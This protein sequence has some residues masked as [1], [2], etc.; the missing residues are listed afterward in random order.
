M[1]RKPF[2]YG[3]CSRNQ[4][5]V[6]ELKKILK[7]YHDDTVIYIEAENSANKG[8]TLWAQ[9]VLDSYCCDERV[10]KEDALMLVGTIK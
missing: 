7:N 2:M 5:T 10:G 3:E 8:D 4:M 6:G 9:K 1:R